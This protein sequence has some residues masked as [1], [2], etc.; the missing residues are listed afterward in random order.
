[1]STL[2]P[3][4]TKNVFYAVEF[5]YGDLLGVRTFVRYALR[6]GHEAL[7]GDVFYSCPGGDLETGTT[8]VSF[9][10][11][12]M[13]VIL[14]L[15]SATFSDIV[16]NGDP[17]PETLVRVWEVTRSLISGAE[18][19][20]KLVDGKVGKVTRNYKGRE[21]LVGLQ[22]VSV[23]QE[24]ATPMGIQI[25]AQCPWTLG[26]EACGVDL[27]PKY[28]SATIQSI[29]NKQV[30]VNW[31]GPSVVLTEE[32]YFR[33]YLKYDDLRIPIRAWDY[34]NFTVI[35][36]SSTPPAFWIGKTV[37]VVPGC[38]K[39]IDTCRTRWANEE[40]FGGSGFKMPAYKP[41]FETPT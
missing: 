17:F 1:M 2:L 9:A 38:D 36:T 29:G 26:S 21:G 23:K 14:P 3:V 30:T 7:F 16:S 28:D 37:I 32:Y 33:G 27:P 41:N 15:R 35:G 31:V 13:T 25:N 19:S 6:A 18:E 22:C 12:P 4:A 5:E 24:L 39:T 10:D 40:R 8:T 20:F 11:K 34:T